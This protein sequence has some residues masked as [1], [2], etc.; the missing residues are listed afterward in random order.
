MSYQTEIIDKIIKDIKHEKG[1]WYNRFNNLNEA[2]KRRVVKDIYINYYA[3]ITNF[4]LDQDKSIHIMN[5]GTLNIKPSRKQYLDLMKEGLPHDEII[6][7]VKDSYR[8][9]NGKA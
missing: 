9:L 6:Q 1:T 7:I 3:A 5:I 4:I 2:Q 8:E